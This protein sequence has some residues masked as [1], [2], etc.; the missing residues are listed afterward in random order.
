MTRSTGRFARAQP[1]PIVL[2]NHRHGQYVPRNK[3][4][5][6]LALDGAIVQG[7]DPKQNWWCRSQRCR[8]CSSRDRHFN[9]YLFDGRKGYREVACL[10]IERPGPPVAVIAFA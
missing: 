5:L 7:S 4:Q 9:S 1:P 3:G 6:A 10:T 2:A 8:R